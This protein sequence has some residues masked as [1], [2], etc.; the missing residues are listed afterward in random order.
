MP[1]EILKSA[2][3][4][5]GYV[6]ELKNLN[7][8]NNYTKK[9]IELLKNIDLECSNIYQGIKIGKKDL[10][11]KELALPKPQIVLP[12]KRKEVSVSFTGPESIAE[13]K[14][15]KSWNL[16]K[17]EKNK[18]IRD[19]DMNYDELKDF[20]K[21]QKAKSK[22]KKISKKEKADYSIY[23]PSNVGKI[24]NRFMKTYADNLVSKHSKFFEPL[25]RHFKMVEMEL[26]SR[27]YVSMMLF[28][29]IISLPVIFL[30]FLA[31]NFAFKLGILTILGIS[32]LGMILTFL[33]FYFYPA[34]LIGGRK[35]KIKLE[36][37]FALVYMSAVAG[38]GANP[39]SIFELIAKSDEY[40]ELGKEIKKIMNYVNLFGYNLTNALRS[41]ASTTP[42]PEFKELLNG[43]ISTIETGGDL[44]DY[45]KE[46]SIQA[47]NTYK[48]DRRKQVEAL[49]TYSE[50]YTAILVT[51]PLLLLVTLAII[52]S[53]GGNFGGVSVVTIAWIGIAGVLPLLNIAFMVFV[54]ISQKGI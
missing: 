25:F 44:K 23:S 51:S 4:V 54:N 16:T 1:G 52:N 49:A 33:G 10:P 3:N 22:G 2:K 36:Y 11:K 6:N 45:L 46:K 41:V 37:P 27:T 31:L 50:V 12:K 15:S 14:Y 42:S 5:L 21:L 20:I 32:L 24:A 39:I 47:L 28:F 13:F 7:R 48:L 53:I 9:K 34:S 17:Q 19:L 43:M 30:F 35:S 8:D 38:S 26:L 18:L 29:T 40:P